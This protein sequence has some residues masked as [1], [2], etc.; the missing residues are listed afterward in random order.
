[1]MVSGFEAQ[2][3]LLLALLDPIFT[4]CLPIFFAYRKLFH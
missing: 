4:P 3:E 2:M 1:M